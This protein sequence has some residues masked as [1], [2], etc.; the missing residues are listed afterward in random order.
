ML[1]SGVALKWWIY[2]IIAIIIMLFFGATGDYLYKKRFD[3]LLDEFERK[4]DKHCAD[5]EEAFQ[6]IVDTKRKLARSGGTNIW[7]IL[8]YVLAFSFAGHLP[9]MLFPT[10]Y[11]AMKNSIIRDLSAPAPAEQKSDVQQPEPALG[12]QKSDV[13]QRL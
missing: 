2:P 4:L 6:L 10:Q 13:Q 1:A 11:N 3:G 7:A 12:E 5:D 9:Q 8:L